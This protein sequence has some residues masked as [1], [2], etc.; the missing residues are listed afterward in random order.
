MND[1]EDGES[2]HEY[3]MANDSRKVVMTSPIRSSNRL[4]SSNITIPTDENIE[5][6][7]RTKSKGRKGAILA[8]QDVHC[9]TLYTR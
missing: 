4:D 5:K 7:K 3:F 9:C 1:D 2:L 8:S 6:R